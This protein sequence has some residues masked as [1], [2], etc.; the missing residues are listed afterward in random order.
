MRD[1][2]MKENS[3]PNTFCVTKRAEKYITWQYWNQNRDIEIAPGVLFI[4]I[5]PGFNW[6]WRP[7]W[8]Q[9]LE[10]INKNQQVQEL[11]HGSR[12]LVCCTSLRFPCRK[13]QN[14][15][16]WQLHEGLVP[17]HCT[18]SFLWLPICSM[19]RMLMAILLFCHGRIQ[20]T[21]IKESR[22]VC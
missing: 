5:R 11:Q 1:H 13:L 18:S 21:E 14:R 8:F 17:K 20:N 22:P 3:K 12:F 4:Y 2:P 6:F 16:M 7:R 9:S 19:C 15:F 10:V